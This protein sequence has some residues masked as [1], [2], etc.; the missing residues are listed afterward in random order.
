MNQAIKDILESGL[1]EQYLLG[2]TSPAEDAQVAT[3]LKQ[4]TIVREHFQQL[5]ADFERMAQEEAIAPPPAVKKQ[6]MGTLNQLS[7]TTATPSKNTNKWPLAIA[8]SLVLLMGLTSFF[9]FQKMKGVETEL[10]LVEQKNTLLEDTLKEMTTVLSALESE[11]KVMGDPNTQ[12]YILKGNALSPDAL[13][14]GYVNHK[15]RKVLLDASQLPGLTEDQDYQLWADVEGEMIDMGV[16]QKENGLLAMNYIAGAES[17]NLTIEP[18]GGSEH[19]T[20]SNLIANVY[21]E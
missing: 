21:I 13:A 8:A 17:M 1:L 5:E 19:P 9:I 20:V 10:Q 4:H 18:A 7:P 6:L 12:K 16:V 14:V 2:N 3:W 11:N 15:D